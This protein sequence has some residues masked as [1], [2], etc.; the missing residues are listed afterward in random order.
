MPVLV[1]GTASASRCRSQALARSTQRRALDQVWNCLKTAPELPQKPPFSRFASPFFA[2]NSAPLCL[3]PETTSLP[4]PCEGMQPL[5]KETPDTVGHVLWPL[6]PL[7]SEQGSIR[8]SD[9]TTRN[10]EDYVTATAVNPDSLR[11]HFA[12]WNSRHRVTSR[13]SRTRDRLLLMGRCY[14]V[15]IVQR[16]RPRFIALNNGSLVTS[17]EAPMQPRS[18][19]SPNCWTGSE[20]SSTSFEPPRNELT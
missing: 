3:G 17:A 12:P 16:P 15:G 11:L 5:S 9:T 8:R 4:T 6:P 20:T 7:S 14:R 13:C 18:R 10:A 19:H 2:Q 1:P